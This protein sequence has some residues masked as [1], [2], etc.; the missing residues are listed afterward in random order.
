MIRTI[1]L[2][3]L[4]GM[5][6][7]M[8]LRSL[9]AMR[10]KE[11]YALILFFTGLPFVVLAYWPDGIVFL[12]KHLEIEK[13]TLMVLVLATFVILMLFKLLAV[14]SVQERKITALTQM[15]AILSEKQGLSRPR[16]FPPDPGSSPGSSLGNSPGNPPSSPSNVSA[17][18]APDR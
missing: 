13:P 11:R 10:L 7:L 9:R 18:E 17:S 2:L 8:A 16:K 15:V 1:A 6:L 3:A 14:V 4:G 12:E 5:L